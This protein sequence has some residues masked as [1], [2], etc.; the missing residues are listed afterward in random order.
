MVTPLWAGNFLKDQSLQDSPDIPW[1]INADELE[2]DHHKQEYTA[3]GHVHITKGNRKLSADFACFNQKK[4]M[5]ILEGQVIMTAGE[6]IINGERLELNLKTETGTIY[7]GGLFIADSHFHIKARTIQKVDQNRYSAVQ[8]SLTACDGPKPAWRITARKLDLTIEGYGFVHHA[9]FKIK[10]IPLFY[11]P[12]LFFP[13]KTK[14]QTGFLIPRLGYSN[15]HGSQIDLPFFW[16]INSWSDATLHQHYMHKCGHKLGLEWRYTFDTYSKAALQFDYL[17]D[18]YWFRMKLDQDLPFNFKTSLDLDYLSD[19]DF[20]REFKEGYSGYEASKE[21]FDKHFIRELDDYNDPAKLNRLNL[22]RF[23]SAY[24][25][26][27][28]IRYYDDAAK[29]RWAEEDQTLHKLPEVRFNSTRQ[30]IFN[31]PWLY[32]TLDTEYTNFYR[33][34]GPDAHRY[35]LYTRFYLPVKMGP[36]V[37]EPSAGLRET[38]WHNKTPQSKTL[39]R[40]SYDLK[41]DLD[42]SFF[43]IWNLKNALKHTIRPQLVYTYI[44]DRSQEKYPF[45]DSN[46]RILPENQIS[47]LLLNTWITRKS[48]KSK[49]HYHQVC[50]FL[51]EQKYRFHH[52]IP[53]L[54]P[55][56]AEI[57]TSPLT[58]LSLESDAEWNHD[59]GLFDKFNVSTSLTNH[60][61]DSFLIE[62]RYTHEQSASLYTEGRLNLA[63]GFT[64]YGNFERDLHNSSEIENQVGLFYQAQCW[65]LDL[66]QENEDGDHRIGFMV[67]LSGLL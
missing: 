59:K 40:E 60:R 51:V 7:N 26:N 29:R 22:M 24:S 48:K 39:N 20:L 45:F 67:T 46:D 17:E 10:E 28:E 53:A 14:R 11:T 21:Y 64:V 41:L 13:I 63:Y 1:H 47:M 15:R 36:L 38:V 25:L 23:G 5:I 2:Y 6:D 16:A 54:A 12:F 58:N 43:R 50:R 52:N 3:R 62:H 30:R 27:A 8:A 55:L 33:K 44:P 31:N 34:D 61:K 65:S 56:Y 4:M 37:L 35:D 32:T 19:Q 18:R 57:E 9:V 49:K 42:T 66:N